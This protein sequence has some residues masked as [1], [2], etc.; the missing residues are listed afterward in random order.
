MSGPMDMD[1]LLVEFEPEIKFKKL[2]D[3]NSKT[4]ELTKCITSKEFL[5]L[6]GCITLV[7]MLHQDNKIAIL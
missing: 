4:T 1:D 5:G 6:R 3:R 7:T 2:F